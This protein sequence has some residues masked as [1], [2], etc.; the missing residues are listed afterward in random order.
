MERSK[1]GIEVAGEWHILK[2]LLSDFTNKSVLDLG[3]GYG[4][5]CLYVS[6]QGVNRVTRIDISQKMLE[7]AREKA[8]D[9]LAIS[10]EQKAMEDVA[11]EENQF[12][13][14]ISS[15]AFHYIKDFSSLIEKI[16]KW[17]KDGG[18]FVF[19]VEH[20][21]FTS[22]ENQDWIYNEK[23]EPKYW[24]VDDYHQ[25]ILRQTN[26]L[27]EDVTKYH[28]TVSTYLNCLIDN[29]FQLTKIEESYPPEEALKE[30][31][32]A[33][34]EFRRPMFLLVQAKK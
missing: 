15:L 1:F 9:F 13:V 33:K 17:M 20:P 16:A 11:F 27:G 24:A 28:R 10:Y 12:D 6:E 23:D 3:C 25:E 31:E 29:G 8:K 18:Q 14:V 22:R 34:H 30:N 26:F 19:S 2:E 21:I 32:Y 7:V 4:R 5:H